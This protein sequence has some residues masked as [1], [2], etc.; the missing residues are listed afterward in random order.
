VTLEEIRKITD[1][2]F[3]AADDLRMMTA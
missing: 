3:D 1:A 2:A